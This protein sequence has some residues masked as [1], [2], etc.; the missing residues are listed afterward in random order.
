MRRISGCVLTVVCAVALAACGSSGAGSSPASPR[1]Q[2]LAYF[3]PT[4]PFV[5]TLDTASGSSSARQLKALEQANPSYALGLTALFGRLSQLGIDYNSDLRPLFGN[6][7]ALGLSSPTGSGGSLLLAWVTRNAS[8]LHRLIAKLPSLRSSGH[9]GS[10][11]LYASSRAALAVDGATLVAGR[12]V[13]LVRAALSRQAAHQGI[14]SDEEASATNG[15]SSDGLL[16][17]FG[18]LTGVLSRPG[19][20]SARR[21]PWV[22]AIRG[23][24]LSLSASGQAVSLHVV[25]NTG[26]RALTPS[27]LPLASGVLGPSLVGPSPVEAGVRDPAQF[28]SFVIAAM[29]DSSPRQYAS[30]LRQ[31]AA[32]RRATGVDVATIESLLTGSLDFDSD[33]RATL[34]RA[35]LTR[36]QVMTRL[37]ARLAFAPRPARLIGTGRLVSVGHG[38]YRAQ[39]RGRTTYVG[40]AYGRLVAGNAPLAVIRQFAAAPA[41]APGQ[42]GVA[43]VRV[44]LGQLIAL[45]L[46]HSPAA[47]GLPPVIAQ[48]LISAVGDLTA[49]VQATTGGLTATATIPFHAA[50][51]SSESSG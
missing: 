4:S 49:T 29:R 41:G 46:A 31:A 27:Q 10:A 50:A 30:F 6:P 21:I 35:D 40:V 44:A 28:I 12:S 14:S 24:G 26:G 11:A 19:A 33:G 3:P 47:S 20:A 39:R 45:G 2:A 8:A 23:Y 42:G 1:L 7:L 38:F 48:R 22:Q 13:A 18:N 15:V 43:M 37:L 51:L 32:L 16:E 5:M 34:V 36:P 17:A 9:D 25:L